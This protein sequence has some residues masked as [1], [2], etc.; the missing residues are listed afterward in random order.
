[1]FE[2]VLDKLTSEV[3]YSASPYSAGQVP[4]LFDATAYSAAGGWLSPSAQIPPLAIDPAVVTALGTDA[5]NTLLVKSQ[6]INSGSTSPSTGYSFIFWYP[7]PASDA[8]Y[9]GQKQSAKA[10]LYVE[11]GVI[12]IV[13]GSLKFYAFDGR[14]TT[15]TAWADFAVKQVTGATLAIPAASAIGTSQLDSL[16]QLNYS[17]DLISALTV[18]SADKDKWFYNAD[19][20]Y[21]YYIGNVEPGTITNLL[22][23]S[24][25]LDKSAGSQYTSMLYDLYVNMEAI[26]PLESAV[27]ASS[28]WNLSG[29]NAANIIAALKAVNAFDA[30]E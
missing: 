10:D 30:V 14:A 9:G 11:N 19:D 22:L 13:P 18:S 25:T 20:G 23:E 1:S 21:F 17:A 27:T 3:K 6:V 12:K 4:V 8:V 24:V 28:G 29:A 5:A 2:E 15:Q 7:I 26:Q 16:I